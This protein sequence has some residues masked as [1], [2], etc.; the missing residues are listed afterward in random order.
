MAPRSIETIVLCFI[1]K[2]DQVLLLK[3]SPDK[4]VFPSKWDGIA[5]KIEPGE[6]ALQACFREV[7]EETGL[8]IIDPL[9][10][11]VFNMFDHQHGYER[12]IFIFRADSTR[13]EM[14]AQSDEGDLSWVTLKEVKTLDAIPDIPLYVEAAAR[15]EERVS[16]GYYEFDEQGNIKDFSVTH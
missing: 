13:G 3:R 2:G 15:Y 7:K 11:G 16:F 5:G 4:K 6:T 9:L 10:C 8:H 12:I 14:L 1:F